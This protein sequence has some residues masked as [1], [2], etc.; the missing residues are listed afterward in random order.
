[1]PICIKCGNEISGSVQDGQ[2]NSTF[3]C[4]ICQNAVNL[5]IWEKEEKDLEKK[6]KTNE[7]S[8]TEIKRLDLIKRLIAASKTE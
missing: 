8:S 7:A 1:M 4:E 2:D 3:V 5:P 6:V